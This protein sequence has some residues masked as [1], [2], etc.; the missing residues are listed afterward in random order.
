MIC[1]SIFTNGFWSMLLATVYSFL[2]IIL[3]IGVEI[4]VL[5]GDS[6]PNIHRWPQSLF[7]ASYWCVVEEELIILLFL[8]CELNYIYQPLRSGKIWPNVNFEAEFNRFEFSFPSPR[9]LAL[10]R[11][12]NLVCPT[13]YP[14][15]EG[16][17]LD[18]FLSQGYECYVSSRIWTR[19]TVS[20]S[21]D[22]NHY[23]TGTSIVGW[24]DGW[25]VFTWS[26]NVW[27]SS[28]WGQ[29]M[30]VSSP[31]VSHIDGF[32]DVNP[33][34]IS[35]KYSMYMLANTADQKPILLLVGMYQI[36]SRSRLSP[37]RKWTL[38]IDYLSGCKCVFPGR[39]L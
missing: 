14:L 7:C 28:W 9:L 32:C 12:K 22:D 30:N 5:S 25:I 27:T 23:T 35:S 11:L 24:I 15:L 16:E 21:C 29:R 36:Q 1:I 31:Y 17:L 20:I 38:P 26:S 2:L 8:H 3:M 37:H 19:V 6:R 13:I 39:D 18:S 4:D 33:N 10:P 34:A